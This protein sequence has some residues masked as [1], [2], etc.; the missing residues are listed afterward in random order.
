[1][2]DYLFHLIIQNR[3]PNTVTKEGTN[4]FIEIKE[5][6]DLFESTVEGCAI[7]KFQLKRRIG[8]RIKQSLSVPGK[9]FC[10]EAY[11]CASAPIFCIIGLLVTLFC[12]LN[13]LNFLCSN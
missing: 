13:F 11:Y 12:T 7:F 4:I 6:Q 2:C 3:G 9:M 5:I 8:I 1:M 10:T